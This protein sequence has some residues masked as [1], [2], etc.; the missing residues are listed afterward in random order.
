MSKAV[1]VVILCSVMGCRAGD[2]PPTPVPVPPGN[3]TEAE[4]TSPEA[5]RIA[6]EFIRAN[7]YTQ[8]APE[9]LS[10]L[11]VELPENMTVEDKKFLDEFLAQ[12]RN[13]IMPRA[14]GWRRG[15]RN[16]PK[17][18]TVGFQLVKPLKN[19]PNSGQAVEMDEHG[20]DVWVEHMGFDLRSLPNKL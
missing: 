18:W 1:H 15:R 12:R 6:E 4:I 2:S 16:D 7:G 9:D 3:S 19:D 17:G 13:S 20:S 14:Y 10:K 5:V 11:D 8:D